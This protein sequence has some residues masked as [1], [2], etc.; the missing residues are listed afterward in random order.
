M[1]FLL[2]YGYIGL[3]LASFAAATVL[4][5]S[6]EGLL[7]V[8]FAA[9]FDSTY[10]VLIATLGNWLGGLSTYYLGYVGNWHVLE[11][12]FGAKK[13]KI[14]KFRIHVNK[15]GSLFALLCWVPIIGDVIAVALGI[16]RNKVVPVAFFMLIG[17]LARYVVIAVS[18]MA[19]VG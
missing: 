14:E 13:E 11:T 4:P 5:F 10:C 3:L 16:F 18:Y 17:K 6:S 9:G 8:M 2:E 7:L 1:E 12:Y 15:Y 19:V